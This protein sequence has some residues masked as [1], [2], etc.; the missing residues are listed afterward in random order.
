MALIL[1]FSSAPADPIA[2][3]IW[4]SGVMEEAKAELS[5]EYQRTYFEAR[6]QGMLSTAV[7]LGIHSRKTVLALTRHENN[8]LGRIIRRWDD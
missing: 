6:S 4:L 8:R 3:L 2:R 1:D 7:G 5:R